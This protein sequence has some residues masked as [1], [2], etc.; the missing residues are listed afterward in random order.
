M[1]MHTH[2]TVTK[3]KCSLTLQYTDTVHFLCTSDQTPYT[4]PYS[5]ILSS[6]I[7]QI[8]TPL[9]PTAI[10]NMIFGLTLLMR[11]EH[12]IDNKAAICVCVKP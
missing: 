11:Q 8:N 12:R 9:S 1:P 10:F 5:F 4:I 3:Y 6:T 7:V 2:F